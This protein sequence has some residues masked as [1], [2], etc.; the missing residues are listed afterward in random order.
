[1]IHKRSKIRVEVAV[2]F[3]TISVTKINLK[4]SQFYPSR[5]LLVQS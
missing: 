5:H 1:M 4:R 2:K 3:K